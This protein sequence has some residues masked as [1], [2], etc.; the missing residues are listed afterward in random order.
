M[1]V[2][3]SAD[4]SV[5]SNAGKRKPKTL[6]RDRAAAKSKKAAKEEEPLEATVPAGVDMDKV[7]PKIRARIIK[8]WNK[9]ENGQ[10]RSALRKYYYILS[11]LKSNQ[12]KKLD[13][14]SIIFHRTLTDKVN[15][16]LRK[17]QVSKMSGSQFS[18]LAFF[19]PEKPKSVDARVVI[20]E[21]GEQAPPRERSY[22]DAIERPIYIQ[23][24]GWYILPEKDS[25]FKDTWGGEWSH[26]SEEEEVAKVKLAP[27]NEKTFF[28]R[29]RGV[30]ETH[31][32]HAGNDISIYMDSNQYAKIGASVKVRGLLGELG[33]Y[34]NMTVE[35]MDRLP[36]GMPRNHK[37]KKQQFREK[38]EVAK[39]L[40]NSSK[41]AVPAKSQKP[42]TRKAPAGKSKKAVYQVKEVRPQKQPLPDEDRC[43]FCDSYREDH[44]GGNWCTREEFRGRKAA[45]TCKVVSVDAPLPAEK[46]TAPLD[47]SSSPFEPLDSS[48]DSIIIQIDDSPEVIEIGGPEQPTPQEIR[49][50]QALCLKEV[51]RK[52]DN[53]TNPGETYDFD[54]KRMQRVPV[55][56]H[57]DAH[58]AFRNDNF[59]AFLQFTGLAY[60]SPMINVISVLYLLW[61]IF[62]TDIDFFLMFLLIQLA[63]Y[64]V[65]SIFF[66]R[67]G[68]RALRV[69]S[70]KVGRLL[71][72]DEVFAKQDGGDLRLFSWRT[73]ELIN[74]NADFQQTPKGFIVVGDKLIKHATESIAA[75]NRTSYRFLKT[76]LKGLGFIHKPFFAL[77]KETIS[78]RHVETDAAIEADRRA[79][80]YST[81]ELKE[82][83]AGVSLFLMIR[84]AGSAY[85]KKPVY[86]SL[87]LATQALAQPKLVDTSLN[88]DDLHSR[89]IFAFSNC[90]YVNVPQSS[91]HNQNIMANTIEYVVWF[92][93]RQ[94]QSTFANGFPVSKKEPATFN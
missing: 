11:N 63:K 75:R 74:L 81:S 35:L 36:G 32:Y 60:V 91:V 49:E 73:M 40:H 2:L 1:P 18:E 20:L 71:S 9:T 26:D 43:L 16:E 8:A 83:D 55:C 25:G 51:R 92:C 88:S 65:F 87:K 23:R 79:T 14:N 5:S 4:A 93:M 47:K 59:Y 13:S 76:C 19:A 72:A 54:Y 27:V 50:Q 30:L 89:V 42:A 33:V 46:R 34:P 58:E 22:A 15:K 37:Q 3:K 66:N 28:I 6:R 61:S 77:K 48:S 39:K 84:K 70:E 53:Y 57:E 21:L 82:H 12:L 67:I 24:P 41:P 62:G 85:Y 31:P 86:V 7:D 56:L 45:M 80:S 52:E 64:I 69:A 78:Y 68:H 38:A 44:P 17:A 10:N 90:T 94:R 29:N